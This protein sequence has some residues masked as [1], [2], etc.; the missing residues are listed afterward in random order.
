MLHAT[1]EYIKFLFSSINHHGIHSPF[2]YELVTKCFYDRNYY[3]GYKII[4]EYQSHLI[5]NRSFISVKDL[6]AGSKLLKTN[7]RRISEISK[8][9]GITNKRAQL[10]YRL[11]NYFQPNSILEFGTS[12]GIATCAL[13]LG[14]PKAL[15]TTIEGCPETAA[16]ASNQFN[17]F[18]LNNINLIVSTFDNELDNLK[19]QK[20]DLVYFDGNHTKEA[21]INYFKTLLQSI[22]NDSIIIFDDIHW[23]K[24][25]TE[26]WDTI[27]QEPKVTLTIDTF[28]WGIVFFRTE[29]VTQ[30]YKIRV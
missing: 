3:N 29:Q 17:S 21:T 5:K 10:L 13:S 16:Q 26:A 12:L 15:I 27:K 22:N 28:F 4:S 30:H 6:G 25:M 19:Q 9:A 24:G 7:S 14:N 18:N 1:I 20:F 8:K 11:V 23:S 2:L